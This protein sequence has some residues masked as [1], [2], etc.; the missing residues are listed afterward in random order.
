MRHLLLCF[1]FTLLEDKEAVDPPDC[2][3][4]SREGIDCTTEDVAV[5]VVGL[6]QLLVLPLTEFI[7]VVV[8]CDCC[9][10][11]CCAASTS[12]LKQLMA[13]VD[14]VWVKCVVAVVRPLLLWLHSH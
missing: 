6:Q 14:L 8:R 11:Q 7:V 4:G 1:T 10:H 5:V 3:D 13:A 2:G 9:Q 12:T